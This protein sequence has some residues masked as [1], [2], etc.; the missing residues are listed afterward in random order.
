MY[1]HPVNILK[2]SGDDKIIIQ[3]EELEQ[4][5][6]HPNVKFRKI[7][8]FSIIG[9][10]RKGKSFFLDYCLRYLYA[11]VRYKLNTW[12]CQNIKINI[13]YF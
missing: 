1:G 5:L 7:V 9:A 13:I 11:H 10:Y 6:Q 8:S 3:N 2:F 12:S 4:M